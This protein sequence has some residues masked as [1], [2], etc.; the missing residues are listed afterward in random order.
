[1][2]HGSHFRPARS[3]LTDSAIE[4]ERRIAADL[5]TSV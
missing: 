2:D 4:Q 1:M 5:N 3:S